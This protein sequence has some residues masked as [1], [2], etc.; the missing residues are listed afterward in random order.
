[1]TCTGQASVLRLSGM[2]AHALIDARTRIFISNLDILLTIQLQ[3]MVYLIHDLTKSKTTPTAVLLD[4][5][6]A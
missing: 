2:Q 4:F 1:M 6:E 5:I 3:L